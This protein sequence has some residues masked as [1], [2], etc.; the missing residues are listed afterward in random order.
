MPATRDELTCCDCGTSFDYS[1]ERA[2]F[3]EQGWYQPRHRSEGQFP[4][5]VSDD[6]K[7]H[8]ASPSHALYSRLTALTTHCRHTD[9]ETSASRR[10][11]AGR[12][13]CVPSWTNAAEFES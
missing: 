9:H 2:W 13:Q 3:E 8:K 4:V 11:T 1:R 10:S 6:E 12:V 5:R 7:A